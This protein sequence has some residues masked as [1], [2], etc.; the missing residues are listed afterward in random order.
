MN[1]GLFSL[2]AVTIGFIALLIWVFRP[3]SRKKMDANAR[4]PFDDEEKK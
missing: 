2:L 4:I 1:A 3:G